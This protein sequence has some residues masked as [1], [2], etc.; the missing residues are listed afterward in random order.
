MTGFPY[1]TFGRNIVLGILAAGLATCLGCVDEAPAGSKPATA[2]EPR[3]AEPDYWLSQ[4]A[5]EQVGSRDFTAL[6]DGCEDV[7][8]QNMFQ[9][10]RRDYRAG[11]LTTQPM[12]SKQIFELWRPDAGTFKDSREATTATI[13]RTIYFQFTQQPDGSHVVAPKVLVE[14]RSIIEPKLRVT[15]EQPAVYWYALRRDKVMEER[16]AAAIRKKL[17]VAAPAA[18]ST[19]GEPTQP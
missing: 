19:T 3:T 10:D 15:T 18:A 14:K 4:P 13:R 12:I 16:L 7:A 6:W 11:L 2:I 5:S 9:V 8:R 1:T 17:E